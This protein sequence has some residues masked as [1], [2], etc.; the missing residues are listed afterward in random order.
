MKSSNRTKQREKDLGITPW[1][2][3]MAQMAKTV[4]QMLSSVF[5][6]ICGDRMRESEI[7][8]LGKFS[9]STFAEIEHI[10]EG[11]VCSQT[12]VRTY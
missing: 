4:C 7:T 2:G 8:R 10:F 3:E 5:L 1:L 6:R 12:V 9:S 11:G